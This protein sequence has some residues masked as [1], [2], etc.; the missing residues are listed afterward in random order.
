MDDDTYEHI[1][2][3]QKDYR[4]LSFMMNRGRHLQNFVDVIGYEVGLF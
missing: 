3:L 1:K 4:V 2:D